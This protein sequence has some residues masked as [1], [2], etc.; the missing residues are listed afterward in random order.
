[1]TAKTRTAPHHPNRFVWLTVLLV[2]TALTACGNDTQNDSNPVTGFPWQI[3][4][5]P[6]GT[7]RVFGIVPGRTTLGEAIAQL[8]D[9]NELAIIAAPGETGS[10][11]VYYGH[12]TAGRIEGRLILVADVEPENL[13]SMQRRARRE[14]GTHKLFL[15]EA[16]LPTARRAAVRAI[17]FMPTFNLDEEIARARFG[18]PAKVLPVSAQERHLLYPALGLD[19]VLNADGKDVLQYL[20]PQDFDSYRA[21][22]QIN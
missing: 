5:Q 13:A 20:S 15:D 19:L 1:M 22:L 8:G 18:I 2:V 3:E 7:T 21:R 10:L 17:T 4:R 12:F 14:G 11:E 9:D 16:D 6:D